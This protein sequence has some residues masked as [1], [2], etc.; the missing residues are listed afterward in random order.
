MLGNLNA[1]LLAEISVLSFEGAELMQ[2]LNA[3]HPQKS[4]QLLS[5]LS[6]KCSHPSLTVLALG[7]SL[8]ENKLAS[9]L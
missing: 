3:F 7:F 1:Y 8:T 5:C 6:V 2:N 9:K 4:V